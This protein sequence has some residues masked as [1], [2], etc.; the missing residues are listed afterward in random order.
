MFSL[1]LLTSNTPPL[2]H[3]MSLWSSQL[4]GH[5]NPV[6]LLPLGFWSK[7]KSLISQISSF[8]IHKTYGK[9]SPQ[10][11]IP[12]K[13]LMLP[14][15]VLFHRQIHLP[16][17]IMR[18]CLGGKSHLLKL[19]VMLTTYLPRTVFKAFCN[20]CFCFRKSK[21]FALL[22]LYFKASSFCFVCSKKSKRQGSYLVG[23]LLL[24]LLLLRL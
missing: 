16:D 19:T 2:A 24:L 10:F 15:Q 7:K 11:C 1:P 9:N 21:V 14:L 23:N 20:N 3:N 17:N 12:L 8:R 13:Q 4:P 18:T 22:Y 6:I 5:L